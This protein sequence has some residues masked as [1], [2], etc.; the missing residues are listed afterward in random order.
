MYS[1]LV[2]AYYKKKEKEKLVLSCVLSCVLTFKCEMKNEDCDGVNRWT[3]KKTDREEAGEWIGFGFFHV[4]PICSTSIIWHAIDV[5][6]VYN[7]YVNK[8]ATGI[9]IVC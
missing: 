7:R 2:L 5:N 4:S 3:R 6:V 9:I 1:L 8:M